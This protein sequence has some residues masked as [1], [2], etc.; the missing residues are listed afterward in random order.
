[1]ERSLANNKELIILF[2]ILLLAAGLRL[3]GINWDANQHLH[4]D[5]RFLTMVVQALQLPKN[6]INYLNPSSS[7]MNPYNY[8]YDFYVYGTFPLLIGKFFSSLITLDAYD[9]NNVTLVG[10]FLS[11]IAD[12][13]VVYVI[14]RIGQKTINKKVGLMAAFLY[15]ISVLPIQLSH[16]YAVDTFLMFFLIMSFYFLILF[17]EKNRGLYI[18]LTGVFLGLAAAS[19]IS[20]LLFLPTIGLGFLFYLVKS[21]KILKFS[22]YGLFFVVFTYLTVRLSDP[23]MF[24]DANLFNPLPNPQF[25]A[26]IKSLKSFDNPDAWFPPAVQ[27]VTTKPLIFPLRNL[28]LWGLGL[29][30]GILSIAGVVF[31]LWSIIKSLKI[32]SLVK[33]PF[34]AIGKLTIQQFSQILM[35]LW[36][37]F[38]FTYQGVQYAKNMRYFYPI[39]PFLAL[40]TANF[41]YQSSR[42]LK[43]RV[44]NLF[45]FQFFNFSVFLSIIIWP[46]SFMAIYSHPHSRITASRW[47]YKNIP[48]GSTIT[49]EHWDDCLP[50]GIDRLSPD[51]Y[52][53]EMLTLFDP[54]TPE[55]WEKINA[56]LSHVDYIIMSSNR[57]WGSIPKL[58]ERYPQTAKFYN[59]LFTGK[60]I[61]SGL[62]FTKAAE[63]TSYPTIP[64]LG[65][66]IPDDSADESFTV[67]DHPKVLIYK[68]IN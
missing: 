14:F 22:T 1:M 32:T 56:Q 40:L 7:T 5:E 2:L 55:K 33:K 28:I 38:L 17:L 63:I 46:L 62:Q 68:R 19:K 20:A 52:E 35:L 44:G 61:A 43:K 16:F 53:S 24:A 30:L 21:K 26:N 59:D 54:D 67:Y 27:W 31:S 49:C 13:G 39:Y 6:I 15:S 51:S 8:G 42:Y 37:M 3:Y 60:S 66:K 50:L 57:L 10:R 23:R 18:L 12:V 29:P 64:L 4:P 41:I 58:P 11:A 45:V 65:I 48:R 9:Y 36:V 34:K 25:I 47:I